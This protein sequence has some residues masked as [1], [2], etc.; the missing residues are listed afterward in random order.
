MLTPLDIEAK[1][2]KKSLFGYSVEEV[3][4][5]LDEVIDDYEKLYKEN[6][7]LKDKL[8]M[9]NEGIQYYKTM[10]NTLQ[11]TL[12]LAEKTAE[13]TKSSAYHKGEQIK[14]ESEMKANQ[15][16]QD[17]QNDVY[18]I[19]QKLAHLKG[20]YE[21]AKIQVKQL[22]LTELELLEKNS[23]YPLA[24]TNEYCAITNE[25]IPCQDQ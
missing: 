24:Q 23:I 21:S 9:L 10:E 22:L 19:N 12:I 13:E 8:V 7:E 17:A 14:R 5:F 2:F 1:E 11:N 4:R 20:Q 3:N 16:I 25:D 15:I 6:I 18:K